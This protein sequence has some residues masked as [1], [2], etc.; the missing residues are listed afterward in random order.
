MM[1]MIPNLIYIKI[2][3]INNVDIQSTIRY[4]MKNIDRNCN[5]HLRLSCIHLPTVDYELLKKLKKIIENEELTLDYSIKCVNAC[6]Y[7]QW[8]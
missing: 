5:K 1:D 7:L 2:D 3:H 6:I 8:K 4:I